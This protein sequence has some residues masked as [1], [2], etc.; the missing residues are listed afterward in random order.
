MGS[1]SPPGFD[2][3]MIQSMVSGYTDYV[4]SL[5]S[6]NGIAN[7]EIC[8][9]NIFTQTKSSMCISALT[10]QAMNM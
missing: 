10:T 8:I 7:T 9:E 2:P 3:Q 4:I 5:F 1:S 6:A